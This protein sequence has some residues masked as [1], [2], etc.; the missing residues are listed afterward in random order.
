[1]LPP[2]GPRVPGGRRVRGDG[3]AGG[4]NNGNSLS[5]HRIGWQQLSLERAGHVSDQV[6]TYLGIVNYSMDSSY[7]PAVATTLAFIAPSWA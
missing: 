4:P 7:G 3:R 1:M 2:P 5:L 6:K